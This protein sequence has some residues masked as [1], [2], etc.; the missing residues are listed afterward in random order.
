MS[1]SH[2]PT[3]CKRFCGL[4]LWAVAGLLLAPAIVSAQAQPATSKDG[5]PPGFQP[6]RPVPDEFREENPLTTEEAYSQWKRKESMKFNEALKQPRI[7]AGSPYIATINEGC[8]IRVR[9]LTI[10]EHRLNLKPIRVEI[11][12]DIH[13]QAT[14]AAREVALKAIGAEVDNLLKGN[15]AVRLQGLILLSE[16]EST[17][18]VPAKSLP[19]V[20]YADA[21]PIYFK[22]LQ[23]KDQPE[24]VKLLAAAYTEKVLKESGLTTATPSKMRTEAAGVLVPLML[25]RDGG[26]WYQEALVAA[27]HAVNPATIPSAVA[28]QQQQIVTSLQT[29]ISDNKRSY[30]VRT[31]AALAFGSLSLPSSGMNS[32]AITN[33]MLKLAREISNDYNDGQVSHVKGAFLLQNIY[34]GLKGWKNAAQNDKNVGAA[35]T[36][37]LPP[38]RHALKNLQAQ[39]VVPMD[40]AAL[41]DVNAIIGPNTRKPSDQAGI[42]ARMQ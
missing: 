32:Q 6:P 14:P 9:R 7:P 21:L 19:A 23:D 40:A 13:L 29:I 2:F 20:L 41:A 36:A 37:V 33:D 3:H 38:V 12:R 30:K 4:V 22:V 8:K 1:F 25:K 27:V 17:A 18:A 28:N 10:T 11:Y 42:N 15:L 35:Y 16:L 39:S 5:L 26:E 34:V 24:A 31:R